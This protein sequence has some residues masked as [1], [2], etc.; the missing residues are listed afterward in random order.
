MPHVAHTHHFFTHNFGQHIQYSHIS[1]HAYVNINITKMNFILTLHQKKYSTYNSMGAS[2]RDIQR[3]TT[4]VFG[5][6]IFNLKGS[7]GKG[8]KKEETHTLI[9][10][11]TL[12]LLPGNSSN[13]CPIY[14]NVHLTRRT[15]LSLDVLITLCFT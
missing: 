1:E 7:L 14:F 10:V 13:P 5:M 2:D 12:M 9:D 11:Q 6:N 3:G 4:L 15:S 8:T